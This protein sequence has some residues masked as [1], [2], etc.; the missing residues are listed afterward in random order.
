ML[1][2]IEAGTIGD[3]K[4]LTVE[5]GLNIIGN[6]RIQNLSMG[7]G[8]LVDLGGYAIQL[9]CSVFKEYPL[10][11]TSSGALYHTGTL[12]INMYTIDKRGA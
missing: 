4:T 9:A 10:K 7:G 3:V 12:V 2:D 1:S 11:I 5:L 8:I 6:E